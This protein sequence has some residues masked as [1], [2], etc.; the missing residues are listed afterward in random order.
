MIPILFSRRGGLGGGVT[1]PFTPSLDFSD[2]RNSQY[3][4][5]FTFFW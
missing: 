4:F 5:L 3:Y 2:A 1:P